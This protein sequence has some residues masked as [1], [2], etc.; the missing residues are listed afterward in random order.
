MI[1]FPRLLA[2][3][4]FFVVTAVLLFAAPLL[5]QPPVY[6]A[7]VIDDLGNSLSEGRRVIGLP[8]PV[9]CAILPHTAHS[10]QLA[11]EAHAAG[12]EVLLHLPMEAP[13]GTEEG[14]GRVKAA[15]PPLELAMTIDYN[16]T[17][18][19]HATGVSNHMG[20]V[21]TRQEAP[22]R[23][24]MRILARR[25]GLFFLDS[26]TTPASAAGKAAA[27][28]GVPYLRRHVFLDNDRSPV[29][30][31]QSLATLEAL[32]RRLGAAVA[33]GHPYP[34]TLE[35]LERWLPTL[36]ER[37]IRLVSPSQLLRLENQRGAHA[38]L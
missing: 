21:F 6:V 10:R 26:F 32:A 13:P 2:T 35:A 14:P 15:M 22:M 33:I 36:A 23:E 11:E 1:S 7:V 16:L 5:A 30:I 18:V 3:G 37:G 19:P 9:A 4:C 8:G 25:G 27:E 24:V 29:A 17:T 38:P 34:E 12:K 28:L 31:A 20:S